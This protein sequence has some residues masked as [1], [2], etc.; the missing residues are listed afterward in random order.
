MIIFSLFLNFYN[1]TT[2]DLMIYFDK[3]VYLNRKKDCDKLFVFIFVD[4]WLWGEGTIQRPY[5]SKEFRVSHAK[6]Y[7]HS[8]YFRLC[9]K[10]YVYYILWYASD[11]KGYRTLCS[12]DSMSVKAALKSNH[13]FF[14][15]RVKVVFPTEF[16][17]QF[18][19]N[20]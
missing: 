3:L 18:C 8:V 16:Q 15:V 17:F 9:T 14:F 7:L 1:S 4:V 10:I 20:I 13:F 19:V 12:F 6:T 2:T 5:K 11:G